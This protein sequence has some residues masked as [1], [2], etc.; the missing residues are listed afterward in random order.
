[1]DEFGKKGR[2]GSGRS[3]DTS[4]PARS[5]SESTAGERDVMI[6]LMNASIIEI[7]E[8][9]IWPASVLEKIRSSRCGGLVL[10]LGSVRNPSDGRKV[11]GLRYEA[12][13]EMA[14][15]TMEKIVR[16]ARERWNL[17][18]IAVIHRV[19][20]LAAGEI[21]LLIAVSAPH[22]KEAYRSSRFILEELK[23][24][25]PIWKKECGEKGENWI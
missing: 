7:V 5:I 1:V 20:W 18:N 3:F 24:E 8:E 14:R 22:R 25:V 6:G 11:T 2:L 23:R 13:P 19:G 15:R 12:Y 4:D 10:F 16:R 21:S 9:E 17:G